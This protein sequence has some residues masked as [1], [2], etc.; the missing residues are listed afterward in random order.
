MST[1]LVPSR[2]AIERWDPA[3]VPAFPWRDP[4]TAPRAD[5]VAYIREVEIACGENPASPV[6]WTTLGMAHAV[7]F[8]VD[9]AMTALAKA[10]AVDPASF[11]ARLKC[12]E[13]HYRLR[14]LQDAEDETRAA[15]DL[16]EN[17]VQLSIARR[18]LREIRALG[19]GIRRGPASLRGLA[20]LLSGLTIFAYLAVHW[21]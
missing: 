18:Q 10:C 6:L 5:L 9:R 16:A 8:D 2:T 12:G 7:N 13:L 19:V 15:V 4:Q 14:A 11:W 17:P 3:G 1:A 20:V 21:G